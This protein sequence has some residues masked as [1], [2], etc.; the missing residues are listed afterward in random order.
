[1]ITSSSLCWLVWEGED[2]AGFQRGGM[3]GKGDEEGEIRTVVY[4][5]RG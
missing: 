3:E 4:R 5:R 1:M 2:A